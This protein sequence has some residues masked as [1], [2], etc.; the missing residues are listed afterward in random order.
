VA[1][2]GLTIQRS[3]NN[4]FW[5]GTTWQAASSTRPATGTTS[6]FLAFPTSAMTNGVTYT[7]TVRA[8]DVAGTVSAPVVTT[9]TYDTSAPATSSVAVANHDG[10]VAATVDTFTVTFG[11][12]LDPASVPATATLTL[13]RSNGNTSYGISGLTN[14]LATTG[15]TGYLTSAGTTRTVTFAGSLALSNQNRTVTF[16]VTGGCAGSCTALSTVARSGRFSFT[17]APSLVDL[18]GNAATGTTLAT[19]QVMF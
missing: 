11:E 7:V 2:V 10:A 17:A 8:T 9:F 14:G 19:N 15:A 1:S 5:N 6:W 3:S 13:S 4:Q 12:A 16:T 18:A